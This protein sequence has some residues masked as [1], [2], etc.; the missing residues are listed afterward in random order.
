VNSAPNLLKH[1]TVCGFPKLLKHPSCAALHAI[2][3]P[4]PLWTVGSLIHFAGLA[5]IMPT[6]TAFVL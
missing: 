3:L 2:F 5:S 1:R 6:G 4:R